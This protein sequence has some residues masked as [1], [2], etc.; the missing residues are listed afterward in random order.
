[1]W[2]LFKKVAPNIASGHINGVLGFSTWKVQ[3]DGWHVFLWSTAGH[4][5]VLWEW[6]VGKDYCSLL[7][8]LFA[9][10]ALEIS[11]YCTWNYCFT[12]QDW[13]EDA[14]FYCRELLSWQLGRLRPLPERRDDEAST[15]DCWW[16]AV[17]EEGCQNKTMLLV[18][19]AWLWLLST[20]N[21]WFG[22]GRMCDETR[23]I[24]DML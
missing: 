11:C 14:C 6:G 5:V 18:P 19:L 20:N 8:L 4:R 9:F 22:M 21:S 15:S 10:I 3:E 2:F 24:L 1:M 23:L 16:S 13:S 17:R 7:R 12:L